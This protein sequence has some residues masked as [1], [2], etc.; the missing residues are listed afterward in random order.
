MREAE[1][2]ASLA[3][4]AAVHASLDN[5]SAVVRLLD[6]LC[7]AGAD[8]E[9]AV[10]APRFPAAGLFSE[11]VQINNAEERLRFGRESDGQAAAMW[12]WEDLN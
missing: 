4:R 11:F 8:E 10:L 3:S 7:A 1:Q 12:T 9:T 5:P 2:T 6:S